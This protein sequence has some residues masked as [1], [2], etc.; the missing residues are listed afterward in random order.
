MRFFE[1]HIGEFR[2]TAGSHFRG[3]RDITVSLGSA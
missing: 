3:F 2:S 1:V